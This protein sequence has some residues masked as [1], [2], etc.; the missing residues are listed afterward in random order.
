MQILSGFQGKWS[1]RLPDPI[2]AHV[3]DFTVPKELRLAA[4]LAWMRLHAHAGKCCT[5][6]TEWLHALPKTSDVPL[7]RRA[8][9]AQITRLTQ[10]HPALGKRARQ[11]RSHWATMCQDVIASSKHI[12]LQIPVLRPGTSGPWSH[13]LGDCS[14]PPTI[15]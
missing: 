11:D 9:D 13:P 5:W 10:A 15:C 7:L 2:S 14:N 1:L 4:F 12:W 6:W 8:S 3:W